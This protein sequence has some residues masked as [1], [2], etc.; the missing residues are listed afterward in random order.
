MAAQIRR[1]WPQMRVVHLPTYEHIEDELPDTDILVG[2]SLRPHQF[3]LARKLRWIHATAAGVGQLMFPELRSS[4]VTLTNARGIHTI[5]M[6]EHILGFLIALARHF[7]L[8]LRQQLKRHWAQQEI[9]DQPLRPRELHGQVLL[10]IG[11]GA[12]GRETARRVRP[13]GIHIWAV[14]RSGKAD[15]SLADRIFPASRLEEALPQA[16][17]VVL[18]APETPETHHLL[19]ARR[20]ALLKPTAF[21]INVARGTLVDEAALAAALGQRSFAGAALDVTEEEPLPPES[22]LWSLENVFITPHISAVSEYLWDRQTELLLENL[23]RWF[24]GRELVNLV[25]LKRG[26]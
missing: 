25:D 3:A 26:Y 15:P 18:A 12:I 8:A 1:R 13:L 11:F 4:G 23:D 14:T 6:A 22:P 19:D 9:W 16:D 7:S 5:P 24:S 21:L 2:F 10:F 20:L 17:F